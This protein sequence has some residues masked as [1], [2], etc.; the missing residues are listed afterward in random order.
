MTSARRELPLPNRPGVQQVGDWFGKNREAFLEQLGVRNQPVP[1]AT[2]DARTYHS[3]ENGRDL[4]PNSPFVETRRAS[5]TETG[6]T[7]FVDVDVARW[8]E[9]EVARASVT[10]G[11]TGPDE[12]RFRLFGH[13]TQTDQLDAVELSLAGSDNAAEVLAWL[14]ERLQECGARR[15]R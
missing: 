3:M 12:L 8:N 15:R 4:P 2:T 13:A 10:V 11:V 6:I 1:V 14:A 7:W 5:A 9:T